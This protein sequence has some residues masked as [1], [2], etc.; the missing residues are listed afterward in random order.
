MKPIKANIA[1]IEYIDKRIVYSILVILA[2]I[3]LLLF[4]HNIYSGF[5]YH[6]DILNYKKKITRFQQNLE[7]IKRRNDEIKSRLEDKEQEKIKKNAVFV[8]RLIAL[9]I[10]PWDNLLDTLEKS[11][12][13]GMI[14]NSVVP[15]DDFQKITIDGYAGSMKNITHLL[16]MLNNSKMLQKS[17]LLQLGVDESNVENIQ[18]EKP[19]DIHFAIE[20][21]LKIDSFF[22]T[23]DRH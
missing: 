7:V 3:S 22:S 12:P 8:N 4:S 21:F 17:S 14:L 20:T 10:F 19:A 9:D 11:L 16:K 15:L 18:E 1:T 6:T 5:R 23:N 13:E 2:V